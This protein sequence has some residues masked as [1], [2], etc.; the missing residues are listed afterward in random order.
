MFA[1]NSWN[2]QFWYN[3]CLKD[4]EKGIA[5]YGMDERGV[6]FTLAPIANKTRNEEHIRRY[7]RQ[8]NKIVKLNK[9][10]KKRY[11][12]SFDTAT[13]GSDKRF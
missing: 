5:I 7:K 2:A 9:V 13:I 6:P 11:F 8:R 4:A 1:R 3:Q 12:R 10:A